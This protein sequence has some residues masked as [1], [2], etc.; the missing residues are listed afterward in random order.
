MK[1]IKVVILI[2]N[3]V[4]DNNE[5][6]GVVAVS[7]SQNFENLPTHGDV[8]PECE[9]FVHLVGKLYQYVKITLVREEFLLIRRINI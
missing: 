5:D 2:W 6:F 3:L 9:V 4:N 1:Y 7:D 8:H